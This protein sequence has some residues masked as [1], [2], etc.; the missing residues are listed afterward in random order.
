MLLLAG[1]VKEV[2]E[3]MLP[4]EA[5]ASKME[6]LSKSRAIASA[7]ASRIAAI[8]ATRNFLIF[9]PA[10]AQI[11]YVIDNLLTCPVQ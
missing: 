5:F 11:F 4:E 3:F 10:N 7:T 9:P 8:F 6:I 1:A 2:L